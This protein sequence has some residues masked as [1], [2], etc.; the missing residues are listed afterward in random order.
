M[1]RS[2]TRF[3]RDRHL[4]IGHLAK[5]SLPVLRD[6]TNVLAKAAS[7]CLVPVFTTLHLSRNFQCRKSWKEWSK[8]EP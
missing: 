4:P 6:S 8:D 1:A 7:I 3:Q 2:A 5:T